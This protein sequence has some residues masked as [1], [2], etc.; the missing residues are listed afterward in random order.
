M[1]ELDQNSLHPLSKV[2]KETDMF[3]LGSNLRR[4]CGVAGHFT[5]EIAS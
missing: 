5:K 1:K 4:P 3:D 2:P